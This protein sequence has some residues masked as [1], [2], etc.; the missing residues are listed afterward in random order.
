MN[1][2]FQIMWI[3]VAILAALAASGAGRRPLDRAGARAVGAVAGAHR[4]LAR[5]SDVVAL[6]LAAGDRRALDR[7]EHAGAARSSSPT[8]SS[9]AR[10]TSPGACGSRRSG[11]TSRTSATTRT[12]ARPTRRRSTATGRRSRPSGW[13][14]YGATYVLSSGG[15]LDCPTGAD[16]LRVEP[17]VRDGLRRGRRHDLAAGRTVTGPASRASWTGRQP[18]GSTTIVT[19]G[20]MPLKTLIATL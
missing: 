8:R 18:L 16:R 4:G 7:G 10:S 2:Y 5:A 11:R 13:P 12:R 20:V 3:A 19:S 14:R 17:A 6:S 1:K 9:T 15:V